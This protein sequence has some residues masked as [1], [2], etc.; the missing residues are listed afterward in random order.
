V[1]IIWTFIKQGFDSHIFKFGV[2]YQKRIV[3]SM[4]V[5]NHL[6]VCLKPEKER[7]KLTAEGRPQELPDHMDVVNHEAYLNK[8][9]N[10]APT[11]QHRFPL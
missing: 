7:E 10:S 9:Q 2:L 4:G 5:T 3:R 6:R 1:E 8:I 11:A